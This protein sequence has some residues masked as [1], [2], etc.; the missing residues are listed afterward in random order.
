LK[1]NSQTGGWVNENKFFGGRFQV[2]TSDSFKANVVGI[3]ITSEISYNNNGNVFYSPCLEQLATCVKIE[4]G[5]LNRI[6]DCRT[7]GAT[8]ALVVENTSFYNLMSSTYGR[9]RSVSGVNPEDDINLYEDGKSVILNKFSNVI[10]DSGDIDINCA[11]NASYISFAKIIHM[12]GGTVSTRISASDA[13]INNGLVV[14]PNRGVGAIIS[15]EKNKTF[16]VYR[17]MEGTCRIG[18]IMY[19]ANGAYIED[20]NPVAYSTKSITKENLAHKTSGALQHGY[21]TGANSIEPLIIS[22]PSNCVKAYIGCFGASSNFTLHRLIIKAFN[23]DRFFADANY[24]TPILEAVPRSTGKVGQ[25]V[26]ASSPT[27]GAI[28]WLY[29]GSEWISVG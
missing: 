15:A 25:F 9:T 28:G 29:T 6:Y 1:L 8:A 14:K 11:G 13:E 20:T 21:A 2:Y 10:F 12:Y 16:A 24:D 23:P 3:L 19:D 5:V 4:Y 18:V 17:I 7:E 27:S 22:L 26:K